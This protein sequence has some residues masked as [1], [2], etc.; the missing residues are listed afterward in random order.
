MKPTQNLPPDYHP[1]GTFDISSNTRVLLLLNVL[2]FILFALFAWLFS[3]VLF[4]LRP[5]EAQLGLAIGFSSVA[6]ILLAVLTVIL[7]TAVM[8]VLHEVVHGLLFW[9]FTG[10]IPKFAYKVVYAYAA[11]PSWYL[12]KRQYLVVALAPLVL[13]SLAGV[14]LMLL[15]PADLF[16]S[17]LLFLVMNASGSVGDLWVAV[18]LLRQPA[19]CY[20][21]DRGDAVT[22]YVKDNQP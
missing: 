9:L 14:G 8:I 19:A 7:T 15:I 16:F 3:A 11:A 22:L 21:N 2:G 6:G 4:A 10:A 1:I 17:L 18:W 20:A 13:L 12:P 5:V